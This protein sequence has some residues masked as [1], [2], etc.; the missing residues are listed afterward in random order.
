MPGLYW[1]ARQSAIP[2]RCLSALPVYLRPDNLYHRRRIL[3]CRATGVQLVQ[4][5]LIGRG[6]HQHMDEAALGIRT[7]MGFH[8]E[9]PFI[10]FLGLMHVRGALLVFVL[11]GARRFYNR[12]IHQSVLRHHQGYTTAAYS[13]Y[14]TWFPMSRDADRC[15]L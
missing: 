13:E 15:L 10:A 4:V 6:G 9:V 3:R 1:G 14:G 5:M 8:A 2:R 12:G 7:N 11:G